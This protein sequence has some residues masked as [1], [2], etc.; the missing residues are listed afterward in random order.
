MDLQK[1]DAGKLQLNPEMADIVEFCLG[2]VSSFESSCYK[3]NL[4]L[5]F[6]S[7]YKSVVTYFDKDKLGKILI[8]IMANAI[9]FSYENS[10]IFVTIEMIEDAFQLTVTDNG[11][12]IPAGEIDNVFRR[13]YQVPSETQ[14][15]GTGIGLAYVKELVEFMNGSVSIKSGQNNGTK[16]IISIPFKESVLKD[17]SE[18]TIEIPNKDRYHVSNGF[19]AS[20]FILDEKYENTVLLVEDNDEL[21]SFIADLLKT[22]FNI[23][24]AKNGKEGIQSAFNYIPDIIISDVM[25][26]GIDG[27][28]LCATIKNDERTSHIPVI[29][30]T[31]R[32]SAQSSLEGYQSGADD[33]IIKPFDNEHLK[34]KVRNIIATREAARSKFDFKSILSSDGLYIGNTDKEFIKKCLAVIDRH[35]DDSSFSVEKLAE[36]LAFSSRNFYR[37]I[38][39][40]TN[41]TPAELIRIY[42]LNYARQLLQNSKLKIFEISMAIGYEDANKFRQ[43][44]KKQFGVSPSECIKS[45]IN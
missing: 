26:P 43:A 39:A 28:E 1:L 19:D 35:I 5:K 37:K 12:G 29:L 44:F 38:K 33:Y 11:V 32:D 23:R 7:G 40:I 18:F 15:T 36:E 34:L 9:K 17:S 31:A 45:L 21:A 8:N 10:A 27:F 30:L 24:I 2:I 6:S 13:Y 42:R 3:K 4:I 22:E 41:Q 14:Y 20:E 16:V 25:M